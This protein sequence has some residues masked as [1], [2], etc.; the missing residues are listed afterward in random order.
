ML[1]RK[2]KTWSVKKVLLKK[3][4]QKRANYMKY[5]IYPGNAEAN[6]VSTHRHTGSWATS[7]CALEW[8]EPNISFV[9]L[10][11]PFSHLAQ[12]KQSECPKSQSQEVDAD[13]GV[14]VCV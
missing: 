8:N 10:R 5:S 6:R 3:D 12:R 13:G 11:I 9:V 7:E 1:N 4:S 2:C 14:C